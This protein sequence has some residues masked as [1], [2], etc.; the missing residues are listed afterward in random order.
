[1]TPVSANLVKEICVY[2]KYD[3][4]YEVIQRIYT[5]SGFRRRAHKTIMPNF[6]RELCEGAILT[7][8][9]LTG[10]L[11]TVISNAYAERF[12]DPRGILK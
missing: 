4:P 12:S 2:G 9:P 10:R 8:M 11:G 7:H 5:F 1:M 3:E 6:S